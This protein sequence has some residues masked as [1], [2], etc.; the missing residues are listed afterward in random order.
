MNRAMRRRKK[1]PQPARPQVAKEIP[2]KVRM[3][4]NPKTRKVVMGFNVK[5][6]HLNMDPEGAVVT[7]HQMLT[8]ARLLNPDAGRDLTW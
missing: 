1:Q 4:H 7:A 3:G 6:N 8:C 2:I 5:V